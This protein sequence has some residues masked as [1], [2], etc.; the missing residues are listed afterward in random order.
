[1]A[2]T[3]A[4]QAKQ[5][6]QAKAPKSEFLA[7][8]NSDE[9]KAL[10]KAGGSG[11]LVNGIPSFIGAMVGGGLGYQGGGR[12]KEG[13]VSGDAPGAASG[14][15]SADGP[16]DKGSP[17]QNYVTEV[18]TNPD[19]QGP[20]PALSERDLDF[21]ADKKK[22]QQEKQRRMLE[23]AN[24]GGGSLADN[25]KKIISEEDDE[26]EEDEEVNPRDYTGIAPR[27]MGS[28]FD[29]TGLA[30]GGRVK[31]NIEPMN[32]GAIPV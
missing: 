17:Y 15:P 25:I 22:E 12:D 14:G 5:L 13:N 32:L 3:N 26:D 9:A 11:H 2:I 20:P 29:F 8:I 4:Q 6:L 16:E 23:I 7:Y 28:I 21:I 10:K 24:R 31:S 27:F 18:A 30:D 1:M 19:F